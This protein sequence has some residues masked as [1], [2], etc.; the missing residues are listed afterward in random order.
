[1]TPTRDPTDQELHDEIRAGVRL[2]SRI[3]KSGL[4]LR[5]MFVGDRWQQT[6][7]EAVEDPV[8]YNHVYEYVVNM[9]A[10]MV[11]S[12]PRVDCTSD[13]V[14]TPASEADQAGLNSLFPL[15]RFSETL[16]LLAM[17]QMF[18]FSVACVILEPTPELAMQSDPLTGQ[19]YVPLR[20]TLVRIPPSRFVQD[21]HWMGIGEPAFQG[22]L[23]IK[24]IDELKAEVDEEG[25]PV[26]M[27]DV[28]DS[29]VSDKSAETEAEILGGCHLEAV[30]RKEVAFWEVYLPAQR[31]IYT[32]SI[33]GK[34]IREPREYRGSGR[35]PYIIGGIHA[36]PDSLY[37]LSPL[38]PTAALVEELNLAADKLSSEIGTAKSIGIMDGAIGSVHQKAIRDAQTG[39]V[40]TVPGFSKGM[41]EMLQFGGPNPITAQYIADLLARLDRTSGVSDVVRGQTG[42]GKTA[43]EVATAD[44]HSDIRSKSIH[45][46]FKMFVV[47]ILDRMVEL[48]HDSPHVCFPVTTDDESGNKVSRLF[49]GG[50]LPGEDEQ[51]R[52][53]VTI[54]PYSM[55]YVPEGLQQKRVQDAFLMIQSAAPMIPQM[56]WVKWR[57]LLDDAFRAS[58]IPNGSSRYIDFDMLTQV[59]GMAATQP[60]KPG[61]DNA[62]NQAPGMMGTP[63][64]GMTA[65]ATRQEQLS[66]NVMQPR[67][68]MH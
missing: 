60:T 21:A 42:G 28:L 3:T 18:D 15:I 14:N 33:N 53:S 11:Y 4:R 22:H 59:V 66:Q 55:E 26:F 51:G 6:T 20:P 19:E 67:G 44:K 35:G 56:P 61:D 12:N 38:A 50:P 17:D 9:V 2:R 8:R 27:P 34:F 36:V 25:N 10:S 37:P 45:V 24:H 40:V 32:I 68:I 1:M 31:K 63:G 29:I 46:K 13:G 65:N 48:M 30:D 57:N 41:V 39:T 16:S 5:E 43:T 7:N 54:E 58:N 52:P 62:P 49:I 64:Q 47:D 23:L